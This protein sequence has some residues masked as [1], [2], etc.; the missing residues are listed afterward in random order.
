MEEFQTDNKSKTLSIIYQ[1][2]NEKNKQ[3]SQKVGC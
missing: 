1:S 3:P 2:E